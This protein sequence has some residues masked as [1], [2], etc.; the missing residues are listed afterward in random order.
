MSYT[1]DCCR[2]DGDT[3]SAELSVEEHLSKGPAERVCHDDRWVWELADDAV[4]VVDD[5]LNRQHR[6]RGRVAAELFDLGIHS[7]PAC[8]YDAEA[9]RAI[10]VCAMLQPA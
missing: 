2:A 9:G 6:D 5:P 8:V 10:V 4:V 1:P 7:R 3:G